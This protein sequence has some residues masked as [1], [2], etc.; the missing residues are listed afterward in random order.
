[1]LSG[2]DHIVIGAGSAGCAVAARLAEDRARRVLLLEA[3]PDARDD[4]AVQDPRRW[5]EL[6]GGSYDW[7]LSYAPA[8]QL[9]RRVIPIPRGRA[10]GGSSAINAL[11]WNRGHP[12]DYARW[13]EGWSFA[14]VLP[15]FRRAEDR[16]AGANAWRGAG[17][18]VRIETPRPPHPLALAFLAAAAQRGYPVLADPN[19]ARTEGAFLGELTIRQGRRCSA[20]DAYL[21]RPPPN[22]VIRTEAEVAALRFAG[23]R[24]T[25]VRLADG[26]A[27]EAG[28]GV[29][30]SAGALHSPL[31]LWRSGIGDPE[32][33]A[34]LGVPCRLALPGVG[35]NL[36]DHPL[37]AGVNFAAARPV[38]RPQSLGGR[39]F[40]NARSPGAQRPDLHLLLVQGPHGALPRGAGPVFALSPGLMGS[41]SRGAMRPAAGGRLVIEPAFLAA[42]RDREALLHGLELAQDL[43]AAPALRPWVARPL[44]P[45]GRLGRAAALAFLL[46]RV[47]TFFHCCGT[48]AIGAVVDRR[49]RVFGTEGLMVADASVFPHIPSGNTHA[50]AVMVGER[51][52]AFLRDG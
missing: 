7:G 33:L 13:G 29:V 49:L 41:H 5:A 12:S 22:L 1:M 10:L 31:L 15:F 48:C 42:R 16:A 25:G 2:F 50:P 27:I 3:G 17:G 14:E 30:L 11:L 47:S 20:A 52:A 21:A 44:L 32:D 8:P 34:R 9:A 45:P 38:G 28:A 35:R 24:C 39:A 37:V 6:A 36:Q 43:A 51:A 46:R 26:T 4:A 19:G 23:L 18:P 40:L